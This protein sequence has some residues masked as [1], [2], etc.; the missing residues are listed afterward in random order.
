MTILHLAVSNGDPDTVE[1]VLRY[2]DDVDEPDEVRK[3]ISA[4]HRVL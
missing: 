4:K 1:E 3:H 2:V